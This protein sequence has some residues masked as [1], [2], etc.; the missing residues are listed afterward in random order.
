MGKQAYIIF[1]A[2]YYYAALEHQGLYTKTQKYIAKPCLLGSYLDNAL[3]RAIKLF[4]PTELILITRLSLTLRSF[5][6]GIT[7]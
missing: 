2:V 1:P 7:W 6:A 3:T 4:G 5:M